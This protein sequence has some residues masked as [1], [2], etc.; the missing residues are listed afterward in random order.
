[1]FVGFVCLFVCFFSLSQSYPL[2]WQIKDIKCYCHFFSIHLFCLTIVYPCPVIIKKT[3]QVIWDY[4]HCEPIH[5]MQFMGQKQIKRK[6]F[7]RKLLSSLSQKSTKLSFTSFYILALLKMSECILLTQSRADKCLDKCR[8]SNSQ[9]CKGAQLFARARRLT[10]KKLITL[11]LAF[12]FGLFFVG[13]F[14]FV[15]HFL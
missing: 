6:A 13:F 8:Q 2:I 12:L 1:M 7:Y 3:I 9:R 4:E 11:L 10:E 5:L 15:S 14:F